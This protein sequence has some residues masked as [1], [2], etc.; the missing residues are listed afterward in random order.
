MGAI[1]PPIPK[2]APKM[3][4]SIKLLMSKPKNYFSANHRKCLRILLRN[5]VEPDQATVVQ[6]LSMIDRT[7]CIRGSNDIIF[8]VKPRIYVGWAKTVKFHFFHS[9]LSKQ[10]FL[11]KI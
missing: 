2:V 6:K 3:Y 1:S 9:K 10:P 4:R 5:L 11:L 7:L 8:Q